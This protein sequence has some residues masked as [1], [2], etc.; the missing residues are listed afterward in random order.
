[1]QQDFNFAGV[2][3]GVKYTDPQKFMEALKKASA[4]GEVHSVQ[5]HYTSSSVPAEDKKTDN[6]P[7]EKETRRNA[8]RHC[9]DTV[10]RANQIKNIISQVA[11][12]SDSVN[13]TEKPFTGEQLESMQDI[14]A[15]SIE[16]IKYLISGMCA[17]D[18]AE[19]C[20]KMYNGM[21][22][23]AAEADSESKDLIYEEA[24]YR[25][26]LTGDNEEIEKEMED[27]RKAYDDNLKEIENS[28]N[29]C[30]AAE[31]LANFFNDLARILEI[32]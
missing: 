22:R 6:E 9:D 16:K 28:S 2:L 15:S 31:A 21:V 3:N 20:D 10:N 12:F 17:E 14:L 23:L 18:R 27:L 11:D 13:D 24:K 30:A 1:M 19:F 8:R 29:R 5:Y 7:E 4:A 25:R 32:K 26:E